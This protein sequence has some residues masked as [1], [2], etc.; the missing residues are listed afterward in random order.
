MR[1]MKAQYGSKEGEKVFYASK[2]KGTITGVD[3]EVKGTASPAMKALMK[4]TAELKAKRDRIALMK[5]NKKRK[6]DETQMNWQNKL[7]ESL[8]EADRSGM[9]HQFSKQ[10]T[11][12]GM[13]LK[14]FHDPRAQQARQ[15]SGRNRAMKDP[16]G[17]DPKSGMPRQTITARGPKKPKFKRYS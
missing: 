12:S 8:T 4:R 5:A 7:Y 15:A 9:G 11:R 3:E 2:N 13:K 1:A 16:E 17:V 6:D 10:K 14:G